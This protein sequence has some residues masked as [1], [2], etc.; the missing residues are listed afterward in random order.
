MREKRERCRDRY[1]DRSEGQM[2]E[3]ETREMS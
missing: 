3:R 1:I 2:E